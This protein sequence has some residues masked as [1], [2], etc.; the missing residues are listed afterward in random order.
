M[1]TA[2]TTTTEK[3]ILVVDDSDTVRKLLRTALKSDGY[4]VIECSNGK[5]GLDALQA[6]DVHIIISDVNMPEMD[7]I[8]FARTVKNDPDHRFTPIIM[9]T[10]ESEE[11]M[12]M[13][14]MAAGVRAWLV[15]PF[16]V[17]QLKIAVEKLIR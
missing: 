15:K 9:L 3:T 2:T 6:S 7:G 16:G 11:E 12:K 5:E 10:T 4:N 13:Q 8:S 1:G 17:S 14:G